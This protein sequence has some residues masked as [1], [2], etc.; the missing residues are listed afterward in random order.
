MGFIKKGVVRGSKLPDEAEEYIGKEGK[1]PSSMA[2]AIAQSRYV[3]EFFNTFDDEDYERFKQRGNVVV[4]ISTGS[5]TLDEGRG[6]IIPSPSSVVHEFAKLV[7][8]IVE[9]MQLQSKGVGFAK[10]QYMGKAIALDAKLKV[11]IAK[12]TRK[13]VNYARHLDFDLLTSLIATSLFDDKT[14][15]SVSKIIE[16]LRSEAEDYWSSHVQKGK[17]YMTRTWTAADQYSAIM[18][19]FDK[20]KAQKES[21]PRGIVKDLI[22]RVHFNGL[23]EDLKDKFVAFVMNQANGFL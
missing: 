11:I 13:S 23:E 18:G 10:N 14:F 19:V 2:E 5:M 3:K 20:S 17:E 8:V 9:M 21:M 1:K 16:E 22:S 7:P 6:M 15:A 12:L 4:S